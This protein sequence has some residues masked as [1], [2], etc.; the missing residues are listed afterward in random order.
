[1]RLREQNLTFVG[2]RD[3]KNGRHSARVDRVTW[4]TIGNCAGA[5]RDAALRSDDTASRGRRGVSRRREPVFEPQL[6]RSQLVVDRQSRRTK[7]DKE[8]NKNVSARAASSAR[9]RHLFG[10]ERRR[11]VLRARVVNEQSVEKKPNFL[12]NGAVLT[13]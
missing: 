3:E 11:N 12:N 1:M 5:E 8:R 4:S 2:E 10:E 7:K 9:R 6:K 13:W